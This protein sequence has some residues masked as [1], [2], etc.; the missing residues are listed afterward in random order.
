MT[1]NRVL[2]AVV[3]HPEIS[4]GRYNPIP[5]PFSNMGSQY[6]LSLASPPESIPQQ[7]HKLSSIP[8]APL[9][10]VV[11]AGNATT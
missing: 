8:T 10:A 3:L 11:V 2:V 1:T 6:K 7:V 5:S 4:A 9:G